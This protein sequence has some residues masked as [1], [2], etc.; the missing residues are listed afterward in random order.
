MIPLTSAMIIAA[1]K[2]TA[3]ADSR[4]LGPTTSTQDHYAEFPDAA[5][6]PLGEAVARVAA[7]VNV[8]RE[9]AKEVYDRWCA[10]FPAAWC[11]WKRTVDMHNTN[12][13]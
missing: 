5:F 4:L 3:L 12:V 7:G 9:L 1:A 10:T 8:S 13:K 11:A 2:L 6:N